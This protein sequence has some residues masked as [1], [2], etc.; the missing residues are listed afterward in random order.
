[1]TGFTF[2]L[3]GSFKSRWSTASWFRSGMETFFVGALAAGTAY[4]VGVLLKDIAG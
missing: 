2:F 4:G 3:I 1:M